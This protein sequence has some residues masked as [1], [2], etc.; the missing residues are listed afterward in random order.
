MRRMPVSNQ[1]GKRFGRLVITGIHHRSKQHAYVNVWC[2]CGRTK[3]MRANCITSG[4]ARSCGC[5]RTQK[6]IDFCTVHGKA[7]HPLYT[8]WRGMKCR[9][10]NPNDRCFKNYGARGIKVCKRWIDSF[11]NF[12]EDMEATF[13]KSLTLER[14][15]NNGDYTPKNCRWTTYGEQLNNTRWN[16]K[17]T[18]DGV[19]H[20]LCQWSRVSGI[21]AMTIHR[22]LQKGC[23]PRYAVFARS[24]RGKAHSTRLDRPE[25][26]SPSAPIRAQS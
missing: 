19:T 20:N 23:E 24:M 8:K 10:Y 3:I 26:A 1:I 25:H 2:D 21:H 18:I 14:T 17:I 6:F 7:R 13:R 12:L 5:V 15:N 22:R 9:C 16:R 4:G 11:P